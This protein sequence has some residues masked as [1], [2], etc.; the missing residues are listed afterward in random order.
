MAPLLP[1]KTWVVSA[2][3]TLVAMASVLVGGFLTLRALHFLVS[4][5]VPVTAEIVLVNGTA[6]IVL[7]VV[8]YLVFRFVARRDI[9]PRSDDEESHS[10]PSSEMLWPW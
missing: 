4:D 5:V 10:N 8:G 1:S 3:G 6:G 2:A 7:T 9:S